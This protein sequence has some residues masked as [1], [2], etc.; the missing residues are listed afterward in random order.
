[1]RIRA[2][3]LSAGLVVIAL[4]AALIASGPGAS[5][6]LQSDGS[7]EATPVTDAT[8]AEPEETPTEEADEGIVIIAMWYQQNEDGEIL[9]LTPLTSEDELIYTRGRA[10]TEEQGGRVVFEESRNEDF[11]RIRIGEGNYFDAYPVYPDDPTTAQRWIFF[12]DDP[13]LR[14]ATM[15]MQIVGIRGDYEDWEGTAT[16]ISRGLD[17]GGV[18]ILAIRA[19]EE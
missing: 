17:Q 7:P 2:I 16:F 9:Q 5:A 1:M 14:P 10:Q 19:P 18:M 15:V 11:P 4:L 12:D 8:P 6:R 13:E 3:T